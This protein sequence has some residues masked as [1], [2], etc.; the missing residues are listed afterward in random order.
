MEDKT[1]VITEIVGVAANAIA[2]AVS[3]A[4][5][6]A[7]ETLKAVDWFEVKTVR[8]TIANGK[9]EQYQVTLEVGFRYLTGEEL[10]AWVEQ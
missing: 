7:H 8:G 10:R 5:A 4:I 3:N 6:R 2:P 1:Y 9:V